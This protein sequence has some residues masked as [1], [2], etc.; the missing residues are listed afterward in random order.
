MVQKAH[1]Y[2]N[3]GK[4][5]KNHADGGVIDSAVKAAKSF[6]GGKEKKA[7]PKPAPSTLGDGA[8]AKA[9]REVAGRK[10]RIDQAIEDAGG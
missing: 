3:G 10:N 5:V 7:A 9:G 6:F 8:A 1:K 4:V 2:A